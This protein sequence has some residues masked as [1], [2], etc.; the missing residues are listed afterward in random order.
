M[1]TVG[2]FEAQVYDIASGFSLVRKIVTLDKT[3]NTI[4]LRLDITTGCF[5]QIYANVKKG[6]VNYALVLDR[7][8]IYGRNYDGGV[9]HRHPYENPEPLILAQKELKESP[10]RS[11]SSKF[12]KS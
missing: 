10:W 2:L 7:N 3:A 9:W 12:S 4:K 5:V 1:I 11:S 6:L 8:R